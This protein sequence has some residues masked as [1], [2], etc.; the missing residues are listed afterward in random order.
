MDNDIEQLL[1]LLKIYRRNLQHNIS[2]KSSYGSGYVPDIILNSIQ[3]ARTKIAEIKN[4]L[5][6]DHGIFIDDEA[7]DLS[8]S[9]TVTL[10]IPRG[11]RILTISDSDYELIKLRVNLDKYV[12]KET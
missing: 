12:I 7:N 4:T 11:Y 1:K 3:D 5:E 10:Q 8:D 9:Q 6:D 2:Q